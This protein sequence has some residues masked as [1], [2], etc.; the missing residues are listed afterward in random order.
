M[1]IFKKQQDYKKRLWKTNAL[2][3][4]ILRSSWNMQ[5]E[6]YLSGRLLF[7]S[8][9]CSIFRLR[10]EDKIDLENSVTSTEK[11][12]SSSLQ[13]RCKKLHTFLS[14]WTKCKYSPVIKCIPKLIA[15][16]IVTNPEVKELSYW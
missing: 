4:E 16:E 6:I 9:F 3:I 2:E 8:I 14:T 12:N 11:D 13:C 10:M 5:V 7:S 15:Y 1:I